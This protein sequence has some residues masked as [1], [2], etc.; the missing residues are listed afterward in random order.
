MN[1][2]AVEIDL[3]TRADVAHEGDPARQ[4]VFTLRGAGDHIDV[5]GSYGEGDLAAG[6][7]VLRHGLDAERFA[8]DRHLPAAAADALEQVARPDEVRNKGVG[9]VAV[10]LEG[11]AHLVHLV[12]GPHDHDQVG[13]GHGLALVV[14]DQDGRDPQPLLEQAHLE[15]HVLPQLGVQG[16]QRFI[17]QKEPRLDRERAGDGHALALAAGEL[18][19]VAGGV[20][21]QA[22]ELQKLIDPTPAGGGVRLADPQA[23]GD[24]VADRQMREEGERLEHHAEVALMGGLVGDVGLL[25]QDPAPGGPFEAG[26]EAQ[27]GG[28]AAPRGAQKADESAVRNAQLHVLDGHHRTKMFVNVFEK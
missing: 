8:A 3:D 25:Q 17:Q 6:L 15:L 23:E 4:V 1:P 16:G 24:V 26:D 11:R 10:D 18:R 27:Q 13:H 21:G 14:G 19:D 12:V 28:L 5:L 20:A 9:R 2:I 7:H 22:H